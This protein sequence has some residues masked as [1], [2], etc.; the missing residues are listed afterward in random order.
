MGYSK[1]YV[2]LHHIQDRYNFSME[3]KPEFLNFPGRPTQD[4]GTIENPRWECIAEAYNLQNRSW[5]ELLIALENSNDNKFRCAVI[6]SY[7]VQAYKERGRPEPFTRL[8]VLGTIKTSDNKV[9]IGVRNSK[10]KVTT[11]IGAQ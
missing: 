6:T 2:A 7:D 9:M 11:A 3:V 5:R 10:N 4:Y 1:P 8:A